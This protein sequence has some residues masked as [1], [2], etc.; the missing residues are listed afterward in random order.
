MLLV[1]LTVGAMPTEAEGEIYEDTI[2]LHIL[3]NSDSELDQDL[4]LAIRDEVL[5]KYG[6]MLSAYNS[7]SEAKENISSLLTAI[8]CDVESWI[9]DMG[10]EYG[11]KA[12]LSEEWY[13]RREYDGF[14]LPAGYYS[15]LR[16]I[17]GEGD[18][19]N[20]WCVMY[21]PLCMDIATEQ[22]PSDDG[23]I[24]YTKEELALIKNGEYQIKFKILEELSRAFAKNS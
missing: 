14:T 13:D 3:A 8:E 4:K 22:A 15:S 21:P 5:K 6:Q 20:W 11:A 12:T 23:F 9:K 19:K 10:Y 7:V 24:D 16:I 18:G 1:T 2:R 17:I